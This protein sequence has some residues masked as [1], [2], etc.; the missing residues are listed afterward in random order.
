[1]LRRLSH[2]RQDHTSRTDLSLPLL[3]IFAVVSI[4]A[5]QCTSPLLASAPGPIPRPARGMPIG[6][7]AGAGLGSVEIENAFPNLTFTSMVHLTHSGDGTDRLWVVLQS[8]L[9]MVFA[10]DDAVTSGGMFIDIRSKVSDVGHEEGLLGL[11]FD[12]DYETNGHFFVYYS[13]ANPRRSIISRFSVSAADPNLAD[14][15]S[16]LVILEVSQPFENHN[17]GTIAFGPDGYLYIALGDGGSGGDPLGNGQNTSTL[18]GSIL[19]IDVSGA[20]VEQPY[21]VPADNPL[22]GAGGGTRGEIWAFGLR[23]P[24]KFAFDP[25]SGDLWAGDVGQNDFEEIDIIRPGRNYGWNVMEGFHCFPPSTPSCDQ[26]SLELPI[27]EY[28]IPDE[29][30]AIIGGHVYRGVRRPQLVGAYVYSDFCSGSIWGLRYDGSTVTEQSLLANS[31]QQ[32][33]AIGTDQN[34]ELYFLTFG[35]QIYRFVASLTPTPTPAPVP[36]LSPW[37]LMAIAGLLGLSMIWMLRRRPNA[38][39]S[40]PS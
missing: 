3:G 24:W 4:F 17:G 40:S 22:V 29:G 33:A 34:Q 19:R 36:S 20:T 38:E 23:N 10:N 13:A 16:E 9:I 30:C 14:A 8:G 2:P 12:P 39:R 32:I 28:D 35:G 5:V 21:R 1:M 7:T 6:A 15:Q 26:A 31:G 37:A 27:F 25:V 18:L 11:A